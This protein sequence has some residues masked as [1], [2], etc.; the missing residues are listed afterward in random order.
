MPVQRKNASSTERLPFSSTHV[1]VPVK[2]W[3]KRVLC[4]GYAL[5]KD[6]VCVDVGRRVWGARGAGVRPGPGW[7]GAAVGTEVRAAQPGGSSQAERGQGA[8]R[9]ACT[10]QV[11]GSLPSASEFFWG[12]SPG[13][14]A[15][16]SFRGFP[17]PSVQR[18]PHLAPF[19]N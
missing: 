16:F 3:S 4:F 5:R 2:D 14:I 6:Q 17:D 9:W 19:Q 10:L 15:F 12:Q 18:S 7:A 11:R 1:M 8:A 13:V